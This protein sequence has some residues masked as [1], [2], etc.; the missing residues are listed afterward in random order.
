MSVSGSV[1]GVSTDVD[2]VGLTVAVAD[3]VGAD[4]TR[5]CVRTPIRSRAPLAHQHRGTTGPV[6]VHCPNP[7]RAHHEISRRSAPANHD[8]TALA[9]PRYRGAAGHHDPT[10]F[11]RLSASA[12][13][14]GTESKSINVNAPLAANACTSS[15]GSM[16]RW[17]LP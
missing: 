2:V 6:G 13:R 9:S 4:P 5:P 16:S 15:L 8:T 12:A 11:R 17:V 14:A 10:R 3:H 7:R 1:A